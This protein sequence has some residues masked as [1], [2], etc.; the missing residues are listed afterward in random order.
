MSE[1]KMIQNEI[2]ERRM[3]ICATYERAEV[4]IVAESMIH[5]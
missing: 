3:K 1:E 2:D 4:T 5:L